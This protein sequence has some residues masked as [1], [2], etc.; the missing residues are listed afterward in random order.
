MDQFLENLGTVIG[1]LFIAF[2]FY[3]FIVG[4]NR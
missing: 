1:V 4:E 2:V 3:N